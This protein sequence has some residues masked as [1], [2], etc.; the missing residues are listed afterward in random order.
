MFRFSFT[1]DRWPLGGSARLAVRFIHWP[2][3]SFSS[4]SSQQ[5]QQQLRQQQQH[6]QRQQQQQQAKGNSLENG[7]VDEDDVRPINK[8][9]NENEAKNEKKNENKNRRRPFHFFIVL[10]LPSFFLVAIGCGRKKKKR[11]RKEEKKMK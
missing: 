9:K 11:R 5:Q 4:F 7:R 1:I 3:R 2:F 8:K 10:F 6:Q